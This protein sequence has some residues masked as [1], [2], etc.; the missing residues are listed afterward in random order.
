ML[1]TYQTTEA[2]TTASISRSPSLIFGSFMFSQ[3][4]RPYN[5][6][7]KGCWTPTDGFIL[8]TWK[9]NQKYGIPCSRSKNKLLVVSST[10]LESRPLTIGPVLKLT[11]IWASSHMQSTYRGTL[12]SQPSSGGCLFLTHHRPLLGCTSVILGS[13]SVFSMK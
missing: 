6:F 13:S 11:M 3:Y 1:A 4:S 10:G 5:T 8:S 12:F 7:P 9:Q 2:T